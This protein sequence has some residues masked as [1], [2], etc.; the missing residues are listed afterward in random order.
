MAELTCPNRANTGG[1]PLLKGDAAIDTASGNLVITIN[2]HI[3]FDIDWTGGFWLLV[4]NAITS[5]IQPVVLTTRGSGSIKPLYLFSGIQ[6]TAA[7]LET[8]GDG[9][10]LCFYNA[11]NGKLQTINNNL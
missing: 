5:G 10:L 6:A 2:P 7:E 8:S 9:V 11:S 4:S 3:G 1:F